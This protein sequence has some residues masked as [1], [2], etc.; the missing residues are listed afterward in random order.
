MQDKVGSRTLEGRRL[1]R[2]VLKGAVIVFITAGYSGK[3]FIFEKVSCDAHQPSINHIVLILLDLLESKLAL[4][5]TNCQLW[6]SPSVHVCAK[7][8]QPCGF[9]TR[10]T[11]RARQPCATNAA[12]QVRLCIDFQLAHTG[13][14]SCVDAMY[15][16]M[17]ALGL[18]AMQAKELGVRT[19]IIDGPDSWCQTLQEEE[20][21][22]Q[23]VGIDFSDAE[24]VFD[25]C[26]AAVKKIKKAGVCIE[27]LLMG[28]WLS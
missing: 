19:V 6:A 22:E 17:L 27:H 23:F 28:G 24:T 12:Q 13:L 10:D 3:K 11:R 5:N 1:R 15:L 14:A 4:C 25:R 18:P 26:L 20:L 2:H 16:P 9:D 21:A 8:P 7:F